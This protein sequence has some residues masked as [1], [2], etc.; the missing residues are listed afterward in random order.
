M[1]YYNAVFDSLQLCLPIKPEKVKEKV[2]QFCLGCGYGCIQ[3]TPTATADNTINLRGG[4]ES[5]KSKRKLGW[6]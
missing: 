6:G 4:T 2:H 3:N 5:T 1:K